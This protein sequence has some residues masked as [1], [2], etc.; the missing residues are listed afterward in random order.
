MKAKILTIVITMSSFFS[1]AHADFETI[2]GK[3][4]EYGQSFSN[5][6]ALPEVGKYSGDI[7]YVDNRASIVRSTAQK[8]EVKIVV[9]F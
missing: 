9:E 1:I 3:R 8:E 7:I 6:V 4:Y 2:G 5:G